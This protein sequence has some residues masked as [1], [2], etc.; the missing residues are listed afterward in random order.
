MAQPLAKSPQANSESGA[1]SGIEAAGLRLEQAFARLDAA[2]T[3]A[4]SGHHSLKAD[5][6]KLNL[7]LRASEAEIGHLK[8]VAATVCA[9]LDK[10]IGALESIEE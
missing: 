9:R 5:H 1:I 6:E 3:H 4:T 2:V 8:K 10:T 7:L